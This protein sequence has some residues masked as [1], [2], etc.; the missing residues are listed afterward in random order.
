MSSSFGDDHLLGVS[1]AAVMMIVTGDGLR[2]DG[3]GAVWVKN[4]QTRVWIA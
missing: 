3:L 1:S 2:V 4:G